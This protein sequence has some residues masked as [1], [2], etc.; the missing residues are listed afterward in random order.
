MS[1]SSYANLALPPNVTRQLR[2]RPAYKEKSHLAFEPLSQAGVDA[3]Y[4]Q[5]LKAGDIVAEGAGYIQISA[6]GV[7]GLLGGSPLAARSRAPAGMQG[8]GRHLLQRPEPHALAWTMASGLGCEYA[9][10]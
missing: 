1:N 7:R 9:G 10:A 2:R 3:L 6:Y 4:D 5:L 8:R